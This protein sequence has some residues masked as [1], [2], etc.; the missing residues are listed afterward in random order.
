MIRYQPDFGFLKDLW[1]MGRSGTMLNILKSVLGFGVFA[2]AVVAPVI[3]FGLVDKLKLETSIFSFLGVVLSILLVFR[4]N[5]AY[6]RWWEGRRQWGALVNACRNL[7]IGLESSLP[8]QQHRLR[9]R[10]GLLISNFCLS[11]HWHLR[12][13]DPTSHLM[14]TTRA[15]R[16]LYSG[17]KHVPAAISAQLNT[18]MRDQIA[19]GHLTTADLRNLKPQ[20][21]ILMDVMGACERIK[22]TPI[23]FAYSVYIKLF[24]VMYSLLMP[25][26]LM[27]AFGYMTIPI[28]ML[29]FFAFI[30]LE[31]IAQE[32][33]DPF[34]DDSNDLPTETIARNISATV[35]EVLGVEIDSFPAEEAEGQAY[36]HEH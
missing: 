33:E 16:E 32:I 27:N 4:T 19:L 10:L 26:A 5:T 15:D 14:R 23:P 28:V 12:R 2:S 36:A 7:A 35:M 3:E 1:H 13:A 9:Y 22:N 21:D 31:L 30:G 25:F 29:I 34:G 17:R 6:D 20:A 11:A 8:P 18:L 24:I